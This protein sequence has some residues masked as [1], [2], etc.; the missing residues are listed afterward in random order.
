MAKESTRKASTEEEID[1]QK[2]TLV[3][4]PIPNRPFVWYKRTASEEEV[5]RAMVLT[6]TNI[7]VDKNCWHQLHLHSIGMPTLLPGAQ[8]W[9]MLTRTALHIM[10]N[11]HVLKWEHFPGNI[12]VHPFQVNNFILYMTSTWSI[13]NDTDKTG[14]TPVPWYQ[15]DT[16]YC[17]KMARNST[18]ASQRKYRCNGGSI[19]CSLIKRRSIILHRAG[20]AR[21][22]RHYGILYIRRW[23][24]RVG[25]RRAHLQP[26]RDKPHDKYWM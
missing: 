9:T 18:V 12:H 1:A 2:Q 4:T 21:R 24:R 6:A 22:I 3:S 10:T 23:S 20:S 26:Y 14:S 17:T 7:F 16:M 15:R 25:R 5:Q 13:R 8:K 19:S 11:E